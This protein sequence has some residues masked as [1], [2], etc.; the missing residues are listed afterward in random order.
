MMG[1]EVFSV[2]GFAADVFSRRTGSGG[3]DVVA[4][5]AA[6]RSY[7]CSFRFRLSPGERRLGRIGSAA[8]G[9]VGSVIS[10]AP[11]TRHRS[12]FFLQAFLSDGKDLG[13]NEV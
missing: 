10:T 1:A 3:T 13:E 6:L 11:L 4:C 5:S 12:P 7:L 9:F 8:R 2:T